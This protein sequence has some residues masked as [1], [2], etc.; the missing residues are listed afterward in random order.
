MTLYKLKQL[1]TLEELFFNSV[2]SL[3]NELHISESVFKSYCNFN[4]LYFR[5]G[6][7]C[8]QLEDDVDYADITMESPDYLKS[9]NEISSE[10]PIK[11]LSDGIC[12]M[13]IVRG[14]AVFY[15]DVEHAS[16][17]IGIPEEDINISI[18]EV[19]H[20]RNQQYLIKYLNISY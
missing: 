18:E 19:G 9:F 1:I 20:Y 13:D 14:V 12:V 11:A 6:N 4:Y 3:C 7:Y 10:I 8:L 16:Y 17:A 5:L 15:R 2:S